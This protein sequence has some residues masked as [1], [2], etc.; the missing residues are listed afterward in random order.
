[1]KGFTNLR[2]VT[3]ILMCCGILSQCVSNI[4]GKRGLLK[5]KPF[6]LKKSFLRFL[7]STHKASSNIQTC[8]LI[9]NTL[10]QEAGVGGYKELTP[11]Y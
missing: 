2:A 3:S 8:F 7:R 5:H 4:K 1:M 11:A 9:H 6:L 10:E